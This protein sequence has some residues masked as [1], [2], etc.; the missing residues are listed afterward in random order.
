MGSIQ[1]GSLK[2]LRQL[3]YAIKPPQEI[4]GIGVGERERRGRT[5]VRAEGSPVRE[6]GRGLN[7]VRFS[8]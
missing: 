1:E 7:P 6:T 8:D 3:Q 4:R 5:D 2:I